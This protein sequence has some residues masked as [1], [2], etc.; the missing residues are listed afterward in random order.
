[1]LLACVLV[2]SARLCADDEQVAAK[3]G[4]RAVSGSWTPWVFESR[5][6]FDPG[7]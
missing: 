6:F 2:T 3:P 7:P 4:A 1:M 5:P